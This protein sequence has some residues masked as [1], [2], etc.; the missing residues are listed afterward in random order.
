MKFELQTTLS[1]A[2]V[3]FRIRQLPTPLLRW[4]HENRRI[5]PWREEV[6]PYRVWVSEIMLQ[7]TRVRAAIPYYERF[8]KE[9]PTIQDLAEADDDLLKKL[10]EGLGYYS[11]VRNLKA[12]AVKV[13]EEFGGELPADYKRLQTL[14][15]IGEYTAGA[16]GSIAFGLK[17]PV[18]DGNVLRVFSRIFASHL[19]IMRPQSK[20]EFTRLAQ[21]MLPEE[22]GDF[23]QSLMELGATVCVPNGAPLCEVCPVRDLCAAYGTPLAETL[24]VKTEK[25]ARIKKE[26][27]V[28]VYRC[29]DRY[30][31]QKR[32]ESG[33]LAGM[34]EFVMKDGHLT[35]TQV[36][37]LTGGVVTKLGKS[38][39]IFT[40][41]EWH[42]VGYLVCV[43]TADQGVWATTEELRETF[44]IPAAFRKY[45]DAIFTE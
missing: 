17:V 1:D 8:L 21:E 35:E 4:Y 29:G 34:W 26:Y 30:L 7:Q 32:P 9:L 38:K 5:L 37:T 19:D 44:A 24:P 18:V 27:T 42:M 39:H 3:V 23:N 28:L 12:A 2:E 45:R 15:G 41:V 22:T 11:R 13:M 33:L 16:I 31:V 14:P 40:H 10:W 6:S 20:T 25:A 36:E 43:D